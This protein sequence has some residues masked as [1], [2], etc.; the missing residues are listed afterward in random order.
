[1]T[2]RHSPA[3]RFG[4]ACLVFLAIGTMLISSLPLLSGC[5]TIKSITSRDTSVPFSYMSFEPEK[6]R[7]NK[8]LWVQ[9]KIIPSDLPYEG[10]DFSAAAISVTG[11]VPPGI[12]TVPGNRISP[13]KLGTYFEGTPTEAGEFI[14]TVNFEKITCNWKYDTT[15]Y[16][17]RTVTVKFRIDK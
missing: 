8:P 17:D 2:E 6:G 3:K 4:R 7:V 1:M 14:V 15:N 10:C 16:G 12:K 5:S 11:K 9:L 13:T